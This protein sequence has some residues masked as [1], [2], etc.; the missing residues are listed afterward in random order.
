MGCEIRR[1]A[2][3]KSS[4]GR[5]STTPGW[6]I[7]AASRVPLIG[8]NSAARQRRGTAGTC[9]PWAGTGGPQP[10]RFA[11]SASLQ[12]VLR[13]SRFTGRGQ[14][15][16][17]SEARTVRAAR[18]TT[19]PH[20]AIFSANASTRSGGKKISRPLSGSGWMSAATVNP[21]TLNLSNYHQSWYGFCPLP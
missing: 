2:Q 18:R 14:Q 15:L 16:L 21:G 12:R 8:V 20:R 13:L 17:A 1:P 10:L 19:S 5:Y 9:R 4:Q 7:Q 6:L 3:K 11:V